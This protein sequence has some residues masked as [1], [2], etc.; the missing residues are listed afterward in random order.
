MNKMGFPTCDQNRKTADF[1]LPRTVSDH[2]GPLRM[3]NLMAPLSNT[4]MRDIET[5]VHP[6]TNLATHR[7]SGPIVIDRAKGIRVYDQHGKPYIEGMSGL[8]CAS[9]GFG[10]DE[11]AE[12]AREQIAN[13]SYTHLFASRSHESA[14]EL[15][16]KIKEMSPAPASKVFFTSSGS[17]ANDTQVKL[18]WYYNNARG[19]PEKK[20]IISRLKGYHG[21]TVASASLT[22]LPA[23]HTDFDLPIAGILHT[24]CPHYYHFAEA[25]ESEADFS[26]R[27]AQNLEALIQE[28]GPETIAGFIAEPIMGAGGVILPPENY[29]QEIKKVLDAHDILFIA[30]EVICGFHRTGEAFGSL[31]FDMEPDSISIAKAITSAYAPLGAL[32]VNEDMY[33]A[34]LNQSEKIGTL[35]HGFTYSGHPLATSI[36]LKTLEIYERE[37]IP[38]HV[39]TVSAIFLERLNRL[40]DHDLIGETRGIGLIGAAEIVSDK[41]RKQSFD[42][43]HG[44]GAKAAEYCRD[45][46][47][48]LRPLGDSIGFCPPLIIQEDDI[49]E[50][51]DGVE[52][53]LDRTQEWIRESGIQ[54]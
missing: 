41:G 2:T 10:N 33:R 35:G 7:Q 40:A 18:L 13:L 15:A 21:V 14:I 45:E 50:L 31:T 54:N 5:L 46:G 28:Q 26:R 6:Y 22:G 11:I 16:E 38:G 39:R 3:E 36:G 32:T 42:P 51:F 19:K 44:V 17:E 9:L 23:N 53:A 12:T 48:I 29:F 43:S 8:W 20:K 24:D 49:H 4:D 25:G 52:K 30:D 37:N 1:Q 47:I 27:M 34:M